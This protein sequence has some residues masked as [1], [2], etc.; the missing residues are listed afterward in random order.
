ML[1]PKKLLFIALNQT[2]IVTNYLATTGNANTTVEGKCLAMP[3]DSQSNSGS[4]LPVY[5][6]E[7]LFPVV[8]LHV[9]TTP[10]SMLQE[11]MWW[12]F[13]VKLLKLANKS[14]SFILNSN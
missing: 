14:K 10:I 5:D 9:D 13:Q 6:Q 8:S 1:N 2:Q 12:A 3:I 7:N 4:S 11:L